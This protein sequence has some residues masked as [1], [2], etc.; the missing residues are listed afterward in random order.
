MV[1]S[2]S[3]YGEVT[4]PFSYDHIHCKGQELRLSDCLNESIGD[5]HCGSNEGAGVLCQ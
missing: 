1:F 2:E 4:R 3:K 5:G